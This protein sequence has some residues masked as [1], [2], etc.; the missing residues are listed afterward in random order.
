MGNLKKIISSY[1]FDAQKLSSIYSDE[2]VVMQFF[3]RKNSVILSGIKEVLKL[4]EKEIENKRIKVRYLEEG[5]LINNLEVVLELEGKYQYISIYEGI[6]DGIL[7]R[8]TSLSN[9]AKECISAAQGIEIICMADRSDHYRNIEGDCW[10][11]Y[12]G[13]IRSFS[14]PNLKSFPFYKE[15]S[16]N[17][18]EKINVY[19]SLPHGAIQIFEGD[20]LKTMKKYHEIF[21]KLP[22]IALVDFNNNVI[23][24][25]LTVLKEFG[26][27]LKG[28]RVDT[29]PTI[30]DSS[31]IDFPE[32]RKYMGVNPTLIKKLRE[33]LD[34]FGGKH[35]KIYISSGLTPEKIK[36]FIDE[37]VRVDGFGVGQFLTHINIFFT[38][39]LVK[40]G[41]KKIS[42][43]GRSYRENKRLIEIN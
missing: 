28:V 1:F 38:G 41:D 40:L 8:S 14:A 31:L 42:K 12:V 24:D 10:A 23:E 6:I 27:K 18:K 15:L 37:K 13:G 4:L 20:I 3:Q 25:S 35:V 2:I 32:E 34:S 7:S 16:S 26:K 19:H 43:F 29:H 21:P 39:D 17:E 33:S 9:N 30:K 5:A 36:E 11:Y 22:L